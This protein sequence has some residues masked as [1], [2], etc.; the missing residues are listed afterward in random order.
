MIRFSTVSIFRSLWREWL[1]TNQ[2]AEV[3]WRRQIDW[4]DWILFI[5]VGLAQSQIWAPYAQT[6]CIIDLYINSLF[7][8]GRL[9][10]SSGRNRCSLEFNNFRFDYYTTSI[11]LLQCNFIWCKKWSL[12][13]N[14][15]IFINVFLILV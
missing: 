10:L 5:W 15:N 2:G 3:I 4:N 12:N 8:S 14:E 13:K 1:L 7:F 11:C 9:D 6:G